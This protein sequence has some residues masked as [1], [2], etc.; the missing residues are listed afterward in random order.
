[1]GKVGAV[2]L[3]KKNTFIAS[4][5]KNVVDKVGAGDAMLTLLSLCLMNNIPKDL[6]LFLGS[7]VGGLSVEIIG[8]KKFNFNELIRTIEFAIK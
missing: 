8:I 1:M 2:W 5:A 4:F 6:S 3:Q 7:I